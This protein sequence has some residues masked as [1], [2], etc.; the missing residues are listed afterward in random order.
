MIAACEHP[1]C[2][3]LLYARGYC[4]NH[5]AAK[6][7]SGDLPKLPAKT[8][9][10]CSVAD[11]VKEASAKGRCVQHYR[12]YKIQNNLSV[13]QDIEAKRTARNRK[14]KKEAIVL[15][16][17][18]CVLCGYNKNIAC[19]EFHH[20]N[21][22]EKEHEPKQ[23]LRGRDFQLIMKELSKCLLVCKNC[24]TEIHHPVRSDDVP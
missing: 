10:P 19:L 21:P 14:N 2:T 16:G 4:K 12:A 23:I 18:A 15:M 5:Y 13:Y 9:L 6:R 17:G 1:K 8:K 3:H 20:K 11:C 7:A 22:D 24:H